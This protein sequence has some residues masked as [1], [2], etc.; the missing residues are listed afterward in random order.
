MIISDTVHRQKYFNSGNDNRKV[1]D[2]IKLDL[3][4]IVR[5]IYTVLNA[6][7]LVPN[8]DKIVLSQFL[9]I[10]SIDRFCI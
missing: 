5:Q 6:F 7:F 4:D 3:L 8:Y 2:C 10:V 9:N 1:M